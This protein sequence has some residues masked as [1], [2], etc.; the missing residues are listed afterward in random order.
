IGAPIYGMILSGYLIKE[1]YLISKGAAFNLARN[2]MMLVTASSW[3]V[4]IVVAQG[5]LVFTMTNVIAH[6]LPYIALTC[7]YKDSEAARMKQRSWYRG[8]R[9][10]WVI[11]LLLLI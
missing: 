5:D 8:S 1:V 9:L 10:L 3:Y 2:A 6:G 4:G 11:G 7:V